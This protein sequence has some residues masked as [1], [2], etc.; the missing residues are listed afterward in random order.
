MYQGP[1]WHFQGQNCKF[2][3]HIDKLSFTSARKMLEISW[4]TS[5]HRVKLQQQ[6]FSVKNI[7]SFNF[8]SYFIPCLSN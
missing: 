1:F 2:C 8:I 5:R 4:T 6:N 7:F 3:I